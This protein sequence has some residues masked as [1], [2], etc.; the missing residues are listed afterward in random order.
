MARHF[1]RKSAGQLWPRPTVMRLSRKLSGNS[2]SG[3]GV[4][5]VNSLMLGWLKAW[6]SQ[7]PSL[8]VRSVSASRLVP[9]GMMPS[10]WTKGVS[11]EF[12]DQ[13]LLKEK[14]TRLGARIAMRTQI[15]PPCEVPRTKAFLIPRASR[16]WTFITALSGSLGQMAILGTRFLRPAYVSCS[17]LSQFSVHADV[18]VNGNLPSKSTARS[19][20]LRA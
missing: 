14:L 19:R 9:R 10:I 4:A 20:S 2:Q 13:W 11:G 18:Y 1:S 17:P 12:G 7:Q 8:R 16:T 3:V 6:P 15:Q 5:L